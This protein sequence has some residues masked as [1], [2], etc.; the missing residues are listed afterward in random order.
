MNKFVVFTVP[1]SGS[2]LLIKTLDSHPEIFCAGEIFY[3]SGKTYHPE[4]Q[5]KFWRL[6]FLSNKLHYLLNY[7]KLLL[8]LNKFLNRFFLSTAP[9]TKAKGFKIMHYQTLYT[10]K[11]FNYLK[12]NKVKVILLQ[13]ENILRNALSDLRART[14][15]IYHNEIGVEKVQLP[16]LKVE[17][18]NLEKKMEQI[19]NTQ[20]VMGKSVALLDTLKI[21]YEE[22]DGNWEETIKKILH[23][24]NVS[25]L[26]LPASVKKLN[27]GKLEEMVENYDELRQWLSKKKFDHFVS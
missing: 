8:T 5:Y 17:M 20:K 11:L 10:P 16:K 18:Q 1:R 19:A 9:T 4:H 6:P 13:R 12:R 2:T 22:L 21:S 24:L 23:F 27:P 3:F 7:P 14:T 26:H 15:G 25:V